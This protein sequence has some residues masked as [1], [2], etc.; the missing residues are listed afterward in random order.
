[1]AV[2]R[3]C[4]WVPN[5]FAELCEDHIL[6][7]PNIPDNVI[8]TPDYRNQRKN[9]EEE[10]IYNI[11]KAARLGHAAI[12]ERESRDKRQERQRQS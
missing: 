7:W 11:N 2:C 8:I 12:G 3:Q 9:R 4:A 5:S 6:I 10:K 1:M